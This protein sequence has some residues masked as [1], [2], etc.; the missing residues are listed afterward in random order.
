MRSRSY[1][2]E[3]DALE[4]ATGD[5]VVIEEDVIAVLSQIL[6]NSERPRN[7][8]AAITE[9]NCLLDSFHTQRPIRLKLNDTR[10]A[11]FEDWRVA[12]VSCPEPSF[13]LGTEIR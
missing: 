2:S 11:L 3:Y 5:T 13:A 9:K 1:V 10:I 12:Q 6:E 4:V 8:G 7:V